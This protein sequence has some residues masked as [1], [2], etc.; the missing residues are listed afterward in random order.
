[1]FTLW[2]TG[3]PASGKS[4]IAKRVELE[5]VQ[6]GFD[7][8]NLDADEVRKNLHPK[9]GFSKE[10]RGENNRRIAFLCKLLNKH[11][12]VAIVAAVSPFEEHRLQAREIV[13]DVPGAH[14]IL[15]WVDCPVEVCKKRDPKGL[16]E[17]AERGEIKD[18]TGV[19][20]PY[21]PP[22]RYEIGI[23]TAKDRPE[24]CTEQVLQGLEKLGLLE[25][26]PR[27]EVPGLTP[28]E[29]AQVKERLRQLGYLD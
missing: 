16:Y 14:F 3:L 27:G 25:P 20:H 24:K 21:E 9:L 22:R 13:E 7:V 5:L 17:R 19:N 26:R 2:F 1:M 6:R 18:F 4:T 15:V 28:E 23:D 29:E 8:E 11:K 10:E 12:V